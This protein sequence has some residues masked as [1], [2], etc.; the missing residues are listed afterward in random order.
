MD[1]AHDRTR[2]RASVDAD[3]VVIREAQPSE[4]DAMFALQQRS[5]R[6]LCRGA[7][8]PERLDAWF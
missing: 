8:T 5:V 4:A 2:P 7:Y 6:T 1:S 3:E